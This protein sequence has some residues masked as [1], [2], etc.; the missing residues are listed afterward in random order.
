MT[1]APLP[2]RRFE[3]AVEYRQMIFFQPWGAFNR[4]VFGNVRDDRFGFLIRIAQTAQ[5]H[6]DLIVDDL[7]RSPANELLVFYKSN[8]RLDACRLAVHQKCDRA[9]YCSC[10]IQEAR[11]RGNAQD[12]QQSGPDGLA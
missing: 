2:V 6:R 10:K 9:G 5:G 4:I 3:S 7:E 1:D 8:I 12:R 11:W